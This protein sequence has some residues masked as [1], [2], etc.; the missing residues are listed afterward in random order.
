MSELVCAVASG[1]G[2]DQEGRAFA[3]QAGRTR[4]AFETLLGIE[5][6]GT[7]ELFGFDSGVRA[8]A[9]TW[10][11]PEPDTRSRSCE[12]VSLRSRSEY[13]VTVSLRRVWEAL[14]GFAQASRDGRETGG[15]L[16]GPHVRSWHSQILVSSATESAQQRQPTSMNLDLEKHLLRDMAGL[17]PRLPRRRQLR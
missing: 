10:R 14:R 17:D 15:F 4:I 7:V 3:V 2:R 1:V 11:L 13:Q 6:P 16:L 5:D 8:P 12:L 9:L